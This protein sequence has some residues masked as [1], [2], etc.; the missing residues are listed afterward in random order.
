MAATEPAV[1]DGPSRGLGPA[2][3]TVLTANLASS[4][5]DGIAFTAAPLLAIRLTSDPLLVSG[6]AALAMLPW[7]LL[8]IPSGIV[9]DRIDRR[10]ALAIANGVRTMLALALVTLTATGALTIWWLYLIV[11]LFGAGETLYDGAIRAVLPSIV[12]RADLPRANARIEAGEQIVQT[13]AAAPL[14][15]ALFAVSVLIPLGLNGAVYAVAAALALFLPMAASGR[16]RPP[17]ADDALPWRQQYGAGWQFLR[18]NPMLLRLWLLSTAVGLFFSIGTAVFALYAIERLGLPEALFGAFILT[19]ACG[20]ILGSVLAPRL[21]AR[22]G[23]GPTMAAATIVAALALVFA[24]AVPRLW[25]LGLAYFVAGGA[26]LVWNVLV[27]SLRQSIIPRRL[28]GRVHGTW[29]TLL[30]GVMP[31]GSLVG[32]LLG[33]IDLRVPF[34][35]G[36]ALAT[37]VGVLGFRFLRTLPHPQDV[38]NEDDAPDDPPGQDDPPGDEPQVSRSQQNR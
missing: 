30:W 7:L 5:G 35:V 20:S 27:M 17:H 1:V 26:V 16:D 32:G 24:G 34:L 23:T 18:G 8:A 12:P 3:R 38:R 9:V 22:W 36:G 31:I 11:F 6:V 25:A 4:L 15:S 13:F 33:R 10:R 28:L 14:T 29:R 21:S 37:A 19:G 2:F